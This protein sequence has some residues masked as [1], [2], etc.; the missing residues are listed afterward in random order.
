ME[1]FRN[2]SFALL[3]F[4][5]LTTS[6]TLFYD[7]LPVI[8]DP[9]ILLTTGDMFAVPAYDNLENSDVLAEPPPE[10]IVTFS[11]ID[12]IL[13]SFLLANVQEGIVHEV[14][15]D[16]F[17]QTINFNAFDSGFFLELIDPSQ[18]SLFLDGWEPFNMTVNNSNGFSILGIDMY[19]EGELGTPPLSVPEPSIA[20]L[21]VSGLIA[22]GV[23][24][25]KNRD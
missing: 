25:R 14:E 15:F 22:F 17:G 8:Y 20:L 9:S 13:F 11:S 23:V 19:I 16:T 18:T 12:S 6:A 7:E 10:G 21:M 3:I 2:Y 1:L 5:P 24:R 4:F